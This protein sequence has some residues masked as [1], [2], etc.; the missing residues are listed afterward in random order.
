MPEYINEF[1]KRLHKVKNYGA[2]MSDDI[3]A[4][5]LLMNDNLKQSK[6][7]LIKV[8]ISDLCYN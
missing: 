2:E 5:R 1:E 4:H 7:Q 8:T 6:D 3:L